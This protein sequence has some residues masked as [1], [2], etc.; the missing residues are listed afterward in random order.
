MP[1]YQPSHAYLQLPIKQAYIY[2]LTDG[3]TDGRTDRPTDRPINHTYLP[4]Y[5]DL[6]RMMHVATV[7]RWVRT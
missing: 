6:L 4:I 3:R 7:V 1:T 2:L 5:L